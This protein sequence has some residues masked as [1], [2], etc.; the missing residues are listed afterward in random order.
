MESASTRIKTEYLMTLHA[1]LE[2]PQ[3]VGRDLL[4]YNV[5]PGGWV[6]GPRIRGELVAPTADWLRLMPDGT[7]KLD[8]RAS[9]RADDG[10]IIY[11]ELR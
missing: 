7:A 8:V 4:I 6:R 10:A 9:I 11:Y 5:P 2:A 1:P 3:T